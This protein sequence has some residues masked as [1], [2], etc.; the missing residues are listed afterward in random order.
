MVIGTAGC[1][2]HPCPRINQKPFHVS[3]REMKGF[4]LFIF[5]KLFIKE[6]VHPLCVAMFLFRFKAA[7]R[8]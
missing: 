3:G 5:I 4:S 1:S 8:I 7:K 6:A 2:N